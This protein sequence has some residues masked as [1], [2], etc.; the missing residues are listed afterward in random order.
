MEFIE[1]R[2]LLQDVEEDH[3]TE[4]R[5]LATLVK[6]VSKVLVDLGIPPIPRTPHDSRM[7]SDVLE[8]VDIIIERLQEAYA[9]GHNPWD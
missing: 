6:D 3:I 2:S 1:L 7:T 8:A 5:Q 9:S 4:A